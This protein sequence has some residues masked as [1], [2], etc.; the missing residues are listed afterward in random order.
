MDPI[1]Q[2]A[3]VALDTAIANLL[4]GPVPD[5]LQRSVRVLPSRIGVSGLGGYVGTHDAPAGSI[6]ARR[7][8]ATLSLDVQ[9]GTEAAAGQHLDQVVR[10]LLVRDRG[11]LRQAGIQGLTLQPDKVSPRAAVL[12]VAYEYIELPTAGEGV[13]DGIDLSLLTGLSS[14]R[15]RFLWDVA[16]RSLLGAAQ[17]LAEFESDDGADLDVGSPPGS[18]AFVPA[19][20]HIAQSANARGGAL[21]VDDPKKAGAMLL[22][23]PAGLPLSLRHFVVVVDF[24]SGASGAVGLVFSRPG[25]GDYAYFLASQAEQYHVFGQKRGA[26]YQTL[27]APTLG[28]GFAPG[29][30]H[31]LMIIAEGN[32]LHAE[33]DGTRTLSVSLAEPL[34]PGELGFFTHSTDQARFYRARVVELVS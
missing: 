31:E 1:A 26:L 3:L 27:G 7:V 8:S 23:R 21:A 24:E 33:L 11:L 30:R 12:S 13:I 16:A 28:A 14:R 2:R 34:V 10:G 22:F 20:P 19:G 32:A 4:P 15:P 6:F 9:G 17:P 25:N 18:W 5:G 29:A